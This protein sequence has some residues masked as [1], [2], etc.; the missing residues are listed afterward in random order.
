M[1]KY[2]SRHANAKV[3]KKTVMKM[4]NIPSWAYWVQIATTFLL[5]STEALV[6][7][8]RRMFFL[9]NSTYNTQ[10]LVYAFFAGGTTAATYGFFPLYF[11]E[12]FPTSVRATAQGFCFNF[13]RVIAAV[14]SL[15]TAPLIK[16]LGGSLPH[17]C[18]VLSLI[19]LVGIVLVW[20]GPETKG[21]PLPD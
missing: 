11:P 13:G 19:Y 18:S 2:G 16:L 4:L 1:K 8:S 3:L 17:A 20:F 10:F 9:M 21:Q 12:L 14:G 15:Q 7:P 5:S 6:T